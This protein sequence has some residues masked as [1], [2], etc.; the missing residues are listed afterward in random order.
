MLKGIQ[1]SGQKPDLV[2]YSIVTKG[3]CRQW[4][5]QEA[6]RFLSEMAT[7]GIQPCIF[8]YNTFLAGYAG[9][10]LL[11]K[12]YEIIRHM[13]EH[14]CRPNELAYKTVVSKEI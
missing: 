2:R 6:I 4:I 11:A 3:F 9:K 13:I 12:V 1:N 5:I 8:T 14:N 10:G 7:N